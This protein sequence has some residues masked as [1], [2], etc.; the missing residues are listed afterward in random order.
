MYPNQS[1]SMANHANLDTN[2]PQRESGVHF[3]RVGC[4]L[5]SLLYKIKCVINKHASR[6]SGFASLFKY[7]KRSRIAPGCLTSGSQF[8]HTAPPAPAAVLSA[9]MHLEKTVAKQ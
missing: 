1:P 3:C 4:I 5:K 8:G 6:V 2:A 9:E 7:S